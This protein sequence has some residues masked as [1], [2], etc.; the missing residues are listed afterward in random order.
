M[1]LND[2]FNICE[3]SPS[4]HASRCSALTTAIDSTLQ[5]INALS[6]TYPER[7]GFPYFRIDSDWD[8]DVI[9]MDLKMCITTK[10][11]CEFYWA[12]QKQFRIIERHIA[13]FS[14]KRRYIRS[15]TKSPLIQAVVKDFDLNKKPYPIDDLDPVARENVRRFCET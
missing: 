5:E 10:P 9:L 3:K 12:C 4:S 2:H 7:F 14:Q 6:M 11:S 8:T 13:K 15:T 1:A